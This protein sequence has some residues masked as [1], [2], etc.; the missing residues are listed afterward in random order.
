MSLQN[1]DI[2]FYTGRNRSSE[3]LCDFPRPHSEEVGA[4][5]FKPR[6]AP[7]RARA[8][9]HS[10]TLVIPR[11]S[12]ASAP[13]VGPLQPRGATDRRT[14]AQEEC[15]AQSH[16]KSSWQGLA[17]KLHFYPWPGFQQPEPRSGPRAPGWAACGRQGGLVPGRGK[18]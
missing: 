14:K 4:Q 10:I 18:Y 1:R 5:G 2:A 16:T 12:A 7:L 17:W 13:G 6:S 8:L 9:N 3:G 15:L 11:V